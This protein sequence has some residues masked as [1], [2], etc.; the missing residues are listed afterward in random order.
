M[1]HLDVVTAFLNPGI[2]ND[3]IYMTLPEG[4]PED[5]NAPKIIIRL[6]TFFMVKIKL[7]GYGMTISM[8]FDSLMGSLNPL[9]ILISIFTVTAF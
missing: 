2:N 6:K 5:P 1:D 4:W 7:Y 3:D 9:P 8:P